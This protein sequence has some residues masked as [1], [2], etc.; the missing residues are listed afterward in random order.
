MGEMGIERRRYTN[1]S[2]RKLGKIA[3][4]E[5]GSGEIGR[6]PAIDMRAH[7]FDRVERQRRSAVYVDMK[8]TDARI[9]S[10]SVKGYAHLRCEKRV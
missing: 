3:V 9:E 1:L 2:I 4:C 5:N 7:C 10:D 8:Q 6:E